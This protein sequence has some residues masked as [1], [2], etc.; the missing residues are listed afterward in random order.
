MGK[1]KPSGKGK[2][3]NKKGIRPPQLSHPYSKVPQRTN[4]VRFANVVKRYRPQIKTL[5]WL[6]IEIAVAIKII[7]M[8]QPPS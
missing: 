1:R 6:L 5:L 7:M 8:A 2:R 4:W 3:V